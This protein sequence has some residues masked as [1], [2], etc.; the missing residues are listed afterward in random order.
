MDPKAVFDKKS[1]SHVLWTNVKNE[2]SLKQCGGQIGTKQ[3]ARRAPVSGPS[4]FLGRCRIWKRKSNIRLRRTDRGE[5]GRTDGR[6]PRSMPPHFGT[7]LRI[8]RHGEEN[9]ISRLR[10]FV[11]P[12][13][14]D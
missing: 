14:P 2:G 6:P 3:G 13:M 1:E 7:F 9:M 11:V 4:L 12:S 5:I 8:D 10:E